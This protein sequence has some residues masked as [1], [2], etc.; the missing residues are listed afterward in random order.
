[1]NIYISLTQPP[2][3]IIKFQQLVKRWQQIL[4]VNCYQDSSASSALMLCHGLVYIRSDLQAVSS[5]P[6][7]IANQDKVGGCLDEAYTQISH[8]LY[9]KQQDNT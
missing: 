1:M 2:R 8:E 5:H 9:S 7:S 6:L 4:T 3:K